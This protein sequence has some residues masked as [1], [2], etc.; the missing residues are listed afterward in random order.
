MMEN[1]NP[2]LRLAKPKKGLLSLVFS[3]LFLIVLLLAAQILLYI[4]VLCW[5]RQT[6]RYYAVMQTLFIFAM[7]LYLFNNRMDTSAKLTWL[8]LIA[9]AP[10]LGV[11]LLAFTQSNLGHRQSR[12]RAA[13]LIEQSRNLVPQDEAVLERL[14]GDDGGLTRLHRYLN[15]SGDFP[16]FDH[17]EVRYFPLGENKFAALLPELEK[18]EKFIFLEYFIIEEGYM[19]G[20]VLDVLARKAKAGV[21]V[22]AMYSVQRF[23]ACVFAALQRPFH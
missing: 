6:L 4:V 20:R 14:Q 15:R 23:Y 1:E 21:D 12:K 13:E 8:A 2:V 10:L 22:R 18:A 16:V 3:R 7:V 19:W 11:L 17:T 9:V 5:L